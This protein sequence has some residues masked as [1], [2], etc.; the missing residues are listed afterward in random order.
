MLISDGDFTTYGAPANAYQFAA[1]DELEEAN[2]SLGF[3]CEY[4]Q[5]SK[6]KFQAALGSRAAE[7][8][9]IS[10]ERFTAPIQL[11]ITPPGQYI[12]I[13]LPV[14]ATDAAR[15][16]G[17]LVGEE[18]I[19][20]FPP[21]SSPDFVTT[22]LCGDNSIQLPM[23]LFEDILQKACPQLKVNFSLGAFALKCSSV[24]LAEFRQLLACQ[25]VEPTS[26]LPTTTIP[27]LV[28]FLLHCI[29]ESHQFE[30]PTHGSWKNHKTVALKA[31]E[32]LENHYSA[33]FRMDEL[34][35]FS[36]TSVRSLQRSFQ[37]YFGIT[38]TEYLKA[39]RFNR[40]RR[41]LLSGTQENVTLAANNNGLTHLGRFSL[42][43]AAMFGE[44]PSATLRSL[45]RSK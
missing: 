38:V 12:A 39:L 3:D 29:E 23:A 6:G 33:H 2:Q 21:G 15:M 32:Y 24:R 13:I 18:D 9:I 25:L 19:L 8:G 1:I 43:Y 35:Q 20:F 14:I 26:E 30:P 37:T 44:S 22:R 5:L 28:T 7:N 27:N 10:W 45:S 11:K 40:A 34:C 4:R 31:Q 41:D 36:G 17:Q 42:D 16:D